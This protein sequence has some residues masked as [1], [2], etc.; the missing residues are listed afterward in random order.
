M[1]FGMVYAVL[2]VLFL[3][4]GYIFKEN[5]LKHYFLISDILLALPAYVANPMNGVY[6]DTVR[7]QY[8]LDQIRDANLISGL[9]GGLNW[10]LNYSEYAAEP[11][12]AVYIWIFSFFKNNGMF[13]FITTLLFLIFL[14]HLLL[15]AGKYFQVSHWNLI[16]IQFVI[17]TTFNLFYQI[18]GIRNFLAFMIFAWAIFTDLT[19]TQKHEK[20]EAIIAYIFCMFFHPIA[21]VFVLFRLL[22]ALK[23][24]FVFFGNH[25]FD[26]V[27]MVILLTYNHFMSSIINLL[28]QIS[29]LPMMSSLFSKSQNYVY[30]QTEFSASTG[31]AEVS[32]TSMVFVAL[33]VELLLFLSL[34][35]D[36]VLPK[37]YLTLYLYIIAFTIGSFMNSQIYLRAIM[38]L[39]FMSAPLKALLFSTERLK[40]RT[41]YLMFFYNLMTYATA[42]VLFGYWYVAVYQTVAL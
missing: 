7:F 20:V 8:I 41:V 12:V 39:L 30:G 6:F 34:Y 38:L 27:V 31:R 22:L 28:A 25:I 42:F 3:I 17:L 11:V 10:V 29:E 13:F 18:E 33:I 36:T 4:F 26:V 2:L 35:K 24:K 14:S 1:N 9:S 5:D 37:G 19:A 32:F 21:I 40:D 15:K 16:L 23:N